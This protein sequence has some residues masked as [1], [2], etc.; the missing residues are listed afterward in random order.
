MRIGRAICRVV[1]RPLLADCLPH[2]GRHRLNAV[3]LHR[4]EPPISLDFESPSV[5]NHHSPLATSLFYQSLDALDVHGLHD[6]HEP[7]P[8]DR[9]L[10]A[11]YHALS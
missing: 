9:V 10:S 6:D 7:L 8:R 5:Q 3:G 1:L 11:A 4:I 2:Q